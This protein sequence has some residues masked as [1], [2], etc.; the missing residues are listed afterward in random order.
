MFGSTVKFNSLNNPKPYPQERME[1][2]KII[3]NK[4]LSRFETELNGEVAYLEYKLLHDNLVIIHTFAPISMRG[5]GVSSSLARFA[6]EYAIENELRVTV[7]C[8]FVKDYLKKHPEYK[9]KL[10]IIIAK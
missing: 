3:N 8:P 10:K 2:L 4:E 7:Y 9:T 5:K 1:D 6:L